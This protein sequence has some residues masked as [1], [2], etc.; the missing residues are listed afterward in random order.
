MIA[1]Y[2][3]PEMGAIWSDARKYQTWLE[4]ELAATDVLAQA[5]VVPAADGASRLTVRAS[6]RSSAR[7]STT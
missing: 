2:T 3:H 5:G 4:V 1:R 7:H 6:R